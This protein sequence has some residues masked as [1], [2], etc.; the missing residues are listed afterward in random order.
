VPVEPAEPAEQEPTESP[1]RFVEVT[2]TG[3]FAGMK[4]TGQ[5]DLSGLQGEELA[6]WQSALHEGLSGLEP[7]QA[8][9]DS[10]IY[11]VKDQTS[12][13]DVTVGG[14]ELPEGLR[15]LLDSAVRPPTPPPPT[16]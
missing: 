9:P 3:G 13:L 5:V 12:G 2:R 15:S 4:L 8:A 1:S 7:R 6:A 11:Q 14:H 10:F 16:T